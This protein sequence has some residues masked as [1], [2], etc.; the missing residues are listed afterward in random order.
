[1]IIGSV[2]LVHMAVAFF[3]VRSLMKKKQKKEAFLYAMLIAVSAYS[4]FARLAYLPLLSITGGINIVFD[5]VENWIEK[6]LGGPFS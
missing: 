1:M 4:A 3:G 6:A 2:L 5:P